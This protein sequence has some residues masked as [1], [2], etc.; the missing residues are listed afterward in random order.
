MSGEYSWIQPQAMNWDG[1]EVIFDNTPGNERIILN[2]NPDD[3]ERVRKNIESQLAR[4]TE[5]LKKPLSELI[6][7]SHWRGITK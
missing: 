5:R 6:Q 3:V 1:V 7:E 4:S 2:G